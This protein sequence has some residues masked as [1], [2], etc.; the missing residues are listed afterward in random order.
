MTATLTEAKP[1][2]QIRGIP[3]YANGEAPA[4][5]RS[6]SQLYRGLRLN[7]AP[8]QQPVCFVRI[9]YHPGEPCALY[10][11]ADA[12]PVKDQSIGA[13]WAWRA[14]RT[15]PRCG[16][17]REYVVH[18]RQCGACNLAERAEATAKHRRTCSDCGRVGSKPIPE[19]RIGWYPERLCRHCIAKK[20]RQRDELL[21]A[22]ILCPGGCG[23]RTA[24]KAEVLQ[25]ALTK[26]QAIPRW[27]RYCPPCQAVHDAEAER[28]NAE[29]Q[30]RWAK[31]RAEQ[32]ERDRRAR[33]ARRQQ[34]RELEQWARDM[35][36]D[37]DVV[38]LDTETT[39]LHDTARIV[40]I[41]VIT[42]AG[43]VLLDTLLNPGEPIP[44]EASSIHGITDAMVTGAPT[45]GEIL[46][47][48]RTAVYG[49]TVLIYNDFFDL[50]RLGHELN[51]HHGETG[52]LLAV[53]R[54]WL[55]VHDAKSE[56]AMVP[57]SDWY[58]EEDDWHGGYRWQRLGGAHRALGDCRAV[59]DVLKA[60]AKGSS[61]EDEA[62][63]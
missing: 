17:V 10:D 23:K 58:G 40:D 26:H 30:A 48:L 32:E 45:F 60:M 4:H 15:C 29:R 38:I 57:Y 37:P 42:A 50:Q 24:T 33:E 20:R 39:G 55:T 21:C 36:T 34:V 41:A 11:P 51:V 28:E 44:A 2:G 61:D 7:P 56:D 53:G 18:G 62:D 25:W 47:S 52:D 43:E 9:A 22:A 12:V 16:V 49:K 3:L 13:L 8:G 19:T 59:I 54:K 5:L 27:K 6:A 31:Q 14:R 46:P 1:I 35:L 63:W